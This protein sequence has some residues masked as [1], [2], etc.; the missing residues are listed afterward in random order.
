MVWYGSG[1]VTRM[2][3]HQLSRRLA[4]IRSEPAQETT[5]G[6]AAA[7]PAL[8]DLRYE[9]DAVGNVLAIRDRAPACGIPGSILGA[10]ALDRAF[11]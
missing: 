11:G 8:Q 3:Y 6:L 9:H 7:G 5:T 4:R 1:V 2:A 10:D